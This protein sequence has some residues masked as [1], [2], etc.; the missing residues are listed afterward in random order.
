M[1]KKILVTGGS[2]LLGT[3]V[4]AIS[5][6]YPDRTFVFFGSKDCDLTRQADTLRFVEK[7]QPDAIL[8]LAAVSGG[9]QFSTQ[10]PATLLRDNVLMNL[11]VLEA[12]RQLGVKKTVMTLSTGMYPPNAPNPLR[13]EYLHDGYPHESNYSYSFAKRLI[14]PSIKAYRAEYGLSAIGLI[15]NGI[16]GEN[17]NFKPAES[18][19]VAALIR[20]FYEER[21]T[22]E[23]IVIW[24][25]GSPLREYTYSQDMARAFMWCLDH[26]DAAQVLHIGSTEEHSVKETAYMIAEMLGIDPG[27]LVFDVSKPAGIFR[28]STD[29]SRFVKL[30][31]F[32]YTPFRI[33]LERT[34]RWFEANYH[35]PGAVRL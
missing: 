2:G 35:Q 4:K 34:I 14:D 6:N 3:A 1:Y 22:A 17:G 11:N 16:F 12:A 19:M 29:N 25:D 5:A 26:Y 9:I 24:G 18:V 32:D 33:G 31:G 20:R 13:E 30:S 8:H 10:F 7:H 23:P 21:Q 28:K 15:S 27:R